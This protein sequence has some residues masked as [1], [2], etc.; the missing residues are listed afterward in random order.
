MFMLKKGLINECKHF[1]HASAYTSTTV[2]KYVSISVG[3]KHE[4]LF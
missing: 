2:T 3:G 1:L 4:Y